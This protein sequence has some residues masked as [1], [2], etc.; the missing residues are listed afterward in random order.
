MRVN[1]AAASVRA[2]REE[3]HAEHPRVFGFLYRRC[4]GAYVGQKARQAYA[5]APELVIVRR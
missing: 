2:G 4:V 5:V 1:R 3:E